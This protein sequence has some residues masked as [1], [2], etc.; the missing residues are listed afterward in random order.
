MP[1]K[2][3]ITKAERARRALRMRNY[4]FNKKAEDK[5]EP[6]LRKKFGSID[7]LKGE[8]KNKLLSR[9]NKG[10]VKKDLTLSQKNKKRREIAKQLKKEGIPNPIRQPRRSPAPTKKEKAKSKKSMAISKKIRKISLHNKDIKD[11]D[12]EKKKITRLIKKGLSKKKIIKRVGYDY[13]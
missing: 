5:T 8:M 6:K 13:T 2:Y 4:H 10:V 7:K 9:L 11:K 12:K 1:R 3:T